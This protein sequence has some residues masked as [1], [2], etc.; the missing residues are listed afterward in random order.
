[1][2]SSISLF[3][4]CLTTYFCSDCFDRGIFRGIL[5]SGEVDGC[6]FDSW[7]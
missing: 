2:T 7:N 4:A 1:M 3:M 5:H 6:L